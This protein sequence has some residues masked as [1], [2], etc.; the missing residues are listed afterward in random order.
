MSMPAT[1]MIRSADGTAIASEIFGE[2]EALIAV[3]GATC[4]RMP[5]SFVAHRPPESDE[6]AT[7]VIA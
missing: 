7:I 6:N 4:D 3:C 2:A 1:D 5:N